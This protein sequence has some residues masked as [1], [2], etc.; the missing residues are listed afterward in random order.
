MHSTSVGPTVA[1][2]AAV[3]AVLTADVVLDIVLV[4]EGLLVE[5]RVDELELVALSPDGTSLVDP[6]PHPLARRSANEIQ[7]AVP[8]VESAGSRW[9]VGAI[10]TCPSSVPGW[11]ERLVGRKQPANSS[12]SLSRVGHRHR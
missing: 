12:K 11:S 8:H 3:G 2:L 1:G 5:V 6:L 7:P 4:V 9:W 10:T